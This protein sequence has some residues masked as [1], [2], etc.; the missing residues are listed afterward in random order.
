MARHNVSAR[1]SYDDINNDVRKDTNNANN[2]AKM[3]LDTK[4]LW[5]QVR[6]SSFDTSLGSLSN[7]I[8]ISITIPIPKPITIFIAIPD[9]GKTYLE[10][11]P[12]RSM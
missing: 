5:Y 1:I 8:P 12:H 6:M 4:K 10:T 7:P 11:T 9:P 3:P 2:E